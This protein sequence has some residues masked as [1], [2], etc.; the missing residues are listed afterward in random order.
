MNNFLGQLNLTT[1]ER[2]IVVAIFLVVV[3]VLN[4]L[5]VWPHFGEWG[6]LKKQLAE[7]YQD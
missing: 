4:L 1:Q 5:F 3:V 7:L 2:R 6:R